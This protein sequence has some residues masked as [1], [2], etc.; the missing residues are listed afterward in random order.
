MRGD[1]A[2]RSQMLVAISADA[3]GGAAPGGG[4]RLVRAGA[5]R[6]TAAGLGD[7]ALRHFSPHQD[8]V[9]ERLA[10]L[11][12]MSRG[13]CDV[14]LVPVTTALYRL[15]PPSYLAAYTF[16]L[17][18]G[19]N[20]R[21]RRAARAAHARRL[22]ARHA[23]GLARRVQLPRR[24]DRPVPDGQR[25]ALPHRSVRRRDRD[26]PHLRRRHA[27]HASTR[28][29]EVRLLPAREFPLDEDGAHALSRPNSARASRAIRRK[30]R[31]T[32]TSATASC[33][34]GIEYYLPLFF[35]AHRD[36]LRL[37]AAATRVGVPARRRAGAR[38]KHSGGTRE[39]RYELLR[40]DR[41]RP[42]LPP[43]RAVPARR[44]S[45]SARSSRSRA[46]RSCR[47]RRRRATR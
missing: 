21:R 30:R 32:R 22:P 42:L 16:F 39:S 1:A 20:A 43:Q 40:G 11:Y 46:S 38:S 33:P 9:S 24:P 7:A 5:A 26:D 28:C 19:R 8:L 45:S 6:R 18:A 10:T 13:D 15:A 4:D 47:R 34:A 3:A 37:P 27:A 35:D 25:A 12:Q 31:S 29:N 23:G 2:A 14:L 41:G 17:E 36:A 44:C